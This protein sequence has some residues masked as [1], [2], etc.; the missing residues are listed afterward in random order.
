MLQPMRRC[1]K[2]A[3]NTYRGRLLL[4]GTLCNCIGLVG[5]PTISFFSLYAK[6]DR[7]WTSGS[8]GLTVVLAYLMG[9]LGTLLCGLL[10]DRIG[11]RM[12]AAMFFVASAASMFILFRSPSDEVMLIAMMTTM[13]SYQAA[14]TAMSALSSELFPTDSRATG[15]SLTVQVFGQL[16]WTLAP[17]AVGLLAAPMGGLGN[18][19]SLFAAG[20]LV[21][22]MLILAYVPE[23]RGR[24]LEELSP[25]E[26]LPEA[27]PA[28]AAAPSAAAPSN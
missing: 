21:G 7:H 22:V 6:R 18:A 20:P 8:I 26:S 14:R 12:T 13:F 27:P 9:T 19:A 4:I 28:A 1:F 5:G 2:R 10:L 25:D 23:T 11:R 3:D 16:G 24:T 17:L 15:Y